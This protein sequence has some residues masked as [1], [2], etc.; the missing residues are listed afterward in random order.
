MHRTMSISPDEVMFQ[1]TSPQRLFVWY[2]CT[3]AVMIALMRLWCFSLNT[4]P[5]ATPFVHDDLISVDGWSFVHILFYTG[6]GFFLPN[7]FL[8]GLLGGVLFEMLE[9]HLADTPV[10]ELHT[11]WEERGINSLWDI[12]FNSLG[13]RLG[14]IFLVLYVRRKR[15]GASVD[16]P[17][18]MEEPKSKKK[19]VRRK[20]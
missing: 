5:L 16:E 15:G 6:V 8:V 2:T 20:A 3:V 4:D 9:G 10:T 18:Q 19:K 1:D 7:H 14:Q 12:I 17:E 11:F 13:F